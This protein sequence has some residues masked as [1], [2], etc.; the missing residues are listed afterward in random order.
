MKGVQAG[1]GEGRG[2]NMLMGRKL[3]GHRIGSL[4]ESEERE[5]GLKTVIRMGSLHLTFQRNN[6]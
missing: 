2:E 4:R 1:L 3:R 6:K 5:L